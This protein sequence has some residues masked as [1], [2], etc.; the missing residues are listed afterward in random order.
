MNTKR[1]NFAGLTVALLL[2]TGC[3]N[4]G[5]RAQPFRLT[6]QPNGATARITSSIGEIS[7][8]LLAVQNNGVVILTNSVMELVPYLSIDRLHLDELDNSYDLTDAGK[9]P[10]AARQAK[11][12]AVSRYPQGIDAALQQ[13]LL[14]QLH[15]SDLRVA[16]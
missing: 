13:R 2:G 15:Q 7:G 10:G 12:A 11:L 1:S 16:Q 8:E 9:I 3:V 14:A 6:S 5:A 4:I